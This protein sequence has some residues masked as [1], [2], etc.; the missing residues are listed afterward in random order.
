[1]T[2]RKKMAVVLTGLHYKENYSHFSGA[3]FNIDYR[4]YM[5]NIK[6][7]IYDYF[8]NAYDI[9]TFV[10]TDDTIKKDELLKSYKPVNHLIVD[11]DAN[12]KKLKGLQM[13]I[14]HIQTTKTRYEVVLLTRFD[15]YMVESFTSSN[16]NLQK[17][18]I[19]SVLE[20]DHLCDDNLFVF[21]IQYLLGF[22]KLLHDRLLEPYNNLV[23]HN[24]KKT[25][26]K[27]MPINYIHN[28]PGKLVRELSFFKLRVFDKTS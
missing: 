12:Q 5:A 2:Q 16:L 8:R 27:H 23:L 26:E 14:H 1:M 20:Q 15:I 10:C 28:E 9:D 11:C 21:P 13:L 4:P 7:H 6:K 22:T 19:V 3:V 17:L 25:F 24:M 18:N